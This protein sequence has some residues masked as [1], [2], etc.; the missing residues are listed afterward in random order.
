[1]GSTPIF[2][3]NILAVPASLPDNVVSEILRGGAEKV[4]QGIS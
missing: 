1:M 4:S 2:A 3:L